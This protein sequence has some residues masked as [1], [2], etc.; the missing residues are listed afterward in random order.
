[1]AYIQLKDIRIAG[2]ATAV[3]KQTINNKDLIA[4]FG[5]KR[6]NRFIRTTGVLERRVA[7]EYQTASDLGVAATEELFKKKGIDKKTI[8]A[9]VFASHGPDY[10]RPATAHVIQK[11]WSYLSSV[12]VLISLWDAQLLYMGF[13]Y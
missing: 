6:I 11:D 12:L 10:K 9:L 5:E 1:M 4:E 13:R 7:S 2:I 8:G 3:P